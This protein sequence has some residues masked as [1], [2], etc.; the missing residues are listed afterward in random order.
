MIACLLQSCTQFL[1]FLI[2]SV[3]TFP[4]H[5]LIPKFVYR[6]A[7]LLLSPLLPLLLPTFKRS[8]V[9]WLILP[10]LLLFH[11][12]MH[13]QSHRSQIIFFS[14]LNLMLLILHNLNWYLG[15]LVKKIFLFQFHK[16]LLNQAL[17]R[18]LCKMTLPI[19]NSLVLWNL[20]LCPNLIGKMSYRLHTGNSSISPFELF[21]SIGL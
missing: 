17:F 16:L 5:L 3:V 10:T 9:V 8:V 14:K 21:N 1:L 6:Q 4:H 11:C 20:L 2:L 12:K 15:A 7:F 19:F 18:H 13:N